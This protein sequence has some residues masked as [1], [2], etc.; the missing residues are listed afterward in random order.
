MSEN[1]SY[2]REDYREYTPFGLSMY[3]FMEER[4]REFGDMTALS[5]YGIK[6]TYTEMFAKIE[7]AERAL[8]AFGIGN[9]GKSQ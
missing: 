1:N 8:R 6:S 2:M 3:Q 4:A 5:F 9:G 7:E